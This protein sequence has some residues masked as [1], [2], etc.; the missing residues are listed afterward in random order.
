M[1][2]SELKPGMLLRPKDGAYFQYHP[3]NSNAY[4]NG[5]PDS[6]PPCMACYI[7]RRAQGIWRGADRNLIAQ[8]PIIYIGKA[9]KEHADNH[10]YYEYRHRV[11]V[12]ALG[13]EM[14]MASECWRNVEVLDESR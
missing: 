8:K 5:A 10:G 13:R 6:D 4:A 2:V 9:P 14:R 1:K 7:H 12:P 3:A 11:F